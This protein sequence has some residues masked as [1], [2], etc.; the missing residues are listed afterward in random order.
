MTAS[1]PEY[2]SRGET[3]PVRHG[4]PVDTPGPR[5]ALHTP[6]FAADPH[7]AYQYM[8]R[9]FGSLVPVEL[10]PD[11]PATLVIGYDTARRILNDP[12]HFPT[13]PRG[14]QGSVPADSPILPMMKWQPAAR[15]NTGA[16]HARYRAANVAALSEV[17]LPALH[18]IIEDIAVPLINSFCEAGSAD[19][20]TDYA[21]PL[22]FSV[23]N[24]LIGCPVEIGQRLAT[25]T[26]A[27]FNTVRAAEGIAMVVD[28][29]RELIALKRVQPDDDIASR[30][31]AH[32]S[33]LDED[34]LLAAL[35]GL[36]SA[37][38]EPQRNLIANTLLLMLTD[39]RF[40]T[41]LVGGNLS[42]RDALDE[43]LFND[44][45]MANFCTT[46]PRQPVLIDDTWL[47]ADQPVVIS[48]A[49]CHDDPAVTGADRTGNRSHL[50]FSTGPHGCPAT[51]IAYQTVQGA[52]DQLLD[53]L[54]DM[55]PACAADELQWRPGPFH[56]ALTALPVSFPPTPPLNT[57]F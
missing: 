21:F 24:R 53:A 43:V 50:A 36:Y 57:G 8:R 44:P 11:V 16:A 40:G 32:P 35:M 38:I 14:W 19:I 54:P 33:A 4:S 22:V 52:L 20:L 46:Y 9:K 1:F 12:A 7:D 15:Y 34:E 48:I 41:S 37:G 26:A 17:D 13:D 47:P 28:A 2:V 42:T 39:T 49:G 29:L 23:L 18:A 31:I 27:R 30:L 56:R 5:V 51:S 6:E 45:P 3:H 25:G 55:T 10:A